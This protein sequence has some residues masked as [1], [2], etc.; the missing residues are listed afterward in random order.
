METIILASASP[1]RIEALKTVGIPAIAIPP[2]IDEDKIQAANAEKSALKRA[3]AKAKA[4]AK[5]INLPDHRFILAADT[6][7]ELDGEIIGKPHSLAE[8]RHLLSAY[9]GR[10]HR[11]ISALALYNK[12]QKKM[13]TAFEETFVHFKKLSSEEIDWYLKT[14]EWRGVA[15]GYRIQSRAALLIEKIEGSYSGVLGL[16]LHLFYAILKNNGYEFSAIKK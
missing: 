11:L 5:S 3:R 2:N 14:E 10:S 8:A 16:P 9:S 1:R 6:L 12:E 7:I 15:G 13:E 4:L